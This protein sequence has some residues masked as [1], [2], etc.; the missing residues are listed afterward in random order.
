MEIK[1]PIKLLLASISARQYNHSYM[2]LAFFAKSSI[3][4]PA[5]L[6]VVGFLR[7]DAKLTDTYKGSNREL[8]YFPPL[9]YI[10]APMTKA[11]WK[12]G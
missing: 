11:S 2:V 10:F 1:F 3:K 8:C 5:S 4:T 9:C 6:A 7:E 12:R